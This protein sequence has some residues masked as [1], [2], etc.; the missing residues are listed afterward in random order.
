[1]TPNCK[2]T[3]TLTFSNPV[4]KFRTNGEGNII[5]DDEVRLKVPR[6]YGLLSKA[7]DKMKLQMC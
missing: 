1:M 2:H 3:K 5:S 6:D 7:S 4:P